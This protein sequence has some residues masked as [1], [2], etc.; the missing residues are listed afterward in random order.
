MYAIRSYYDIK[1]ETIRLLTKYKKRRIN[2]IDKKCKIN[3]IVTAIER[4]KIFTVNCK[5]IRP[6]NK[7]IILNFLNDSLK[8]YN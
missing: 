6:E 5:E 8:K 3:D 2:N 7:N 4:L 1:R